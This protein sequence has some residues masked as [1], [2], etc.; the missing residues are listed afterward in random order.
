MARTVDI[1]DAE[2]PLTRAELEKESGRELP[3]LSRS[4]LVGVAV[5]QCDDLLGCRQASWPSQVARSR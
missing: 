5:T 2:A 4:T 1:L 3:A